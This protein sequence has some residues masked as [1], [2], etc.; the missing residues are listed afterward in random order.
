MSPIGISAFASHSWETANINTGADHTPPLLDPQQKS[1]QRVARRK[2][3]GA[4]QTTM[5]VLPL[6][7]WAGH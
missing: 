4:Q 5:R 3:F 7:I 2:A 1:L 6:L